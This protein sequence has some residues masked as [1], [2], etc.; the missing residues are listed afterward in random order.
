M[1]ADDLLKKFASK[2]IWWKNQEQALAF[3]DRIWA[4]VMNLGEYVDVQLMIQILPIDALK[5]I[6]LTAQAGQFSA[7]SWHYW[8]YRLG[9][10]ELEMV[11]PL[12]VRRFA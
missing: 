3:P 1:Q 2:Y 4:Q 11:P 7:R 9:M 6:L 5:K 8:H 10:A 12:P